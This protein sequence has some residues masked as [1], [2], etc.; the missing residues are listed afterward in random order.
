[1]YHQRIYDPNHLD[2]SNRFQDAEGQIKPERLEMTKHDKQTL[3]DF[4]TEIDF[5]GFYRYDSFKLK[6]HI[7]IIVDDQKNK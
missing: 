3:I 5:T 2:D 7:N 1:M 4:I 6:V